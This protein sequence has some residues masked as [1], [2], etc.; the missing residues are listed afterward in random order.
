LIIGESGTGKEIIARQI[1]NLSQRANKKFVAVNCGA[2]T[3]TLLESELFG[4]VKGAFTGAANERRGLFEEA[5]GGTIFLDEVTETSLAFQSKLLRVLQEGE[6]MPVGSSTP[7][8]VNARVIAASNQDLDG[9]VREKRFRADLL[10][11]LRVITLPLP[12][13][14]ARR[15]DILLL[16]E[17]FIKRYTPANRPRPQFSAAALDLLQ[18]YDWPGN[19]RELEHAIERAVVLNN[20]NQIS[21]D[22]LPEELR[23]RSIKPSQTIEEVADESAEELLTLAEVEYRHIQKVLKAVDGNKSRAAR[24]LDIDRKTLDRILERHNS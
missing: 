20:D 22:D 10:Y 11:R 12:P 16:A 3:E 19:V 13:L 21:P 9:A 23:H 24:V 2:L 5:N 8:R 1:H 18:T 6:I 14:R 7:T 15:D 17:Y 4:H